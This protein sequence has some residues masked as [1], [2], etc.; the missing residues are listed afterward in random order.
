MRIS[1]A[2]SKSGL[3]ADTIRFYEKSGI[4]P[5]IGR[6]NDGVRNFSPE[7]VEWLTLLFWLRKT[8]MPMRDMKSFASL[9][10]GGNKTMKQRKQVLLDHAK[11]LKIRRLELDQCEEI[12]AHKISIYDGICGEKS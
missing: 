11:R 12:L 5:E 8:G 1:E 7:N 6:N 10:S 9:Y 2:A 4:V 3:S